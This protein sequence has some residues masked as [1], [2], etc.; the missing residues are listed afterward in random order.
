MIT[1][2]QHVLDLGVI[3]LGHSYT[4][5]FEGDDPLNPPKALYDKNVQKVVVQINEVLYVP[6]GSYVQ[7]LYWEEPARGP[8]KYL[9]IPGMGSFMVMPV[10]TDNFYRVKAF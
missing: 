6:Y 10:T 7:M 5:Y 8:K 9:A 1:R 4:R 3:T 2:V